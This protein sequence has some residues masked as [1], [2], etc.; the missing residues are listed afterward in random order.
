MTSQNL[1][2][3][4]MRFLI[5]GDCGRS[6]G[7]IEKRILARFFYTLCNLPQKEMGYHKFSCPFI[8]DERREYLNIKT[9]LFVVSVSNALGVT[10]FISLFLPEFIFFYRLKSAKWTFFYTNA[11]HRD[12]L[13]ICYASL[14]DQVTL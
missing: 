14:N 8:R 12:I 4:K 5:L 10:L 3:S 2:G 9:S 6:D 1:K 13:Y 7:H 11:I